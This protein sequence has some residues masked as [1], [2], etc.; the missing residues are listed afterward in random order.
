MY[1]NRSL[2]IAVTGSLN[3]DYCIYINRKP[4]NDDTMLIEKTIKTP[5]GHGGNCAVAL[6]RLKAN[7]SLFSCIGDDIQGRYLKQDLKNEGV[8][9]KHIQETTLKETGTVYIPC[10]KD[11]YKYMLMNR[12]ANDEFDIKGISLDVLDTYECFIVMD[13]EHNVAELFLKKAQAM[14]K[15]SILGLCRASKVN[16]GRLLRVA[17]P[18]FIILNKQESENLQMAK[19][20]QKSSVIVTQGKEGCVLYSRANSQI[21][22]SYLMDSIID[23]IG[24]GDC[25]LAVFSIVYLLSKNVKLA[26]KHASIA[27]AISTQKSGAREG[28]PTLQELKK[29]VKRIK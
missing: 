3:L 21:F 22:S 5:G 7:V 6:S 8:D 1:K 29:Y 15:L 10:Y 24:A 28:L 2:R 27:G 16:I 20:C 18:T 19:I 25:F 9:T 12:G 17:P 11:R 26:I 4:K 14:N 23:T 13:V